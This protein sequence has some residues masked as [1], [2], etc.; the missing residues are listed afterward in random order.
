MLA[1]FQMCMSVPLRS[2]NDSVK[3]GFLVPKVLKKNEIR[4]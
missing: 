4:N 3:I 1:D 2:G